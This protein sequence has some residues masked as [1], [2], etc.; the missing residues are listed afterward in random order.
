M[1]SPFDLDIGAVI[2]ESA[3]RIIETLDIQTATDGTDDERVDSDNEST[4][5][6]IV[7]EVPALLE[8]D[9]GAEEPQNP[10]KSADAEGSQTPQSPQP[11]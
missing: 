11:P 3:D 6:V 10:Q 4:L 9:H 5:D 2:R 8:G 7:V 1:Y